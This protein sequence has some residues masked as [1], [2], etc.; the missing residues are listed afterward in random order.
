MHPHA[1]QKTE[2]ERFSAGVPWILVGLRSDLKEEG[3]KGMAS[4][5]Y[6]TY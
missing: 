2:L 4:F 3:D 1:F 6:T 5:Q